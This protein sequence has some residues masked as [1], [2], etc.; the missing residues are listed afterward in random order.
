MI[1]ILWIISNH[2][3][4]TTSERWC[5]SWWCTIYINMEYFRETNKYRWFILVSFYF[6]RYSWVY[7]LTVTT[8]FPWAFQ[9][10]SPHELNGSNTS[11]KNPPKPPITPLPK[12]KPHTATNNK[13]H[14]IFVVIKVRLKPTV[15]LQLLRKTQHVFQKSLWEQLGQSIPEHNKSRQQMG[16]FFSIITRKN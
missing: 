14:P 9:L 6:K 15:P 16:P 13:T 3:G 4:H 2:S 12:T 10:D 5:T 7:C 11:K 8:V 1:T